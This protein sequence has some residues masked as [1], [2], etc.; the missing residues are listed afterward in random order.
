MLKP[1]NLPELS[2]AENLAGMMIDYTRDMNVYELTIDELTDAPSDWNFFRPLAEGKFFEL[3]QSIEENGLLVPLIVWERPDGG[4]MILSGHNRKRALDHLRR[5][6]GDDTYGRASCVVYRADS[7]DEGQA[8]GILVDCNWVQRVLSPSEKAR[9]IYTKYVE[10]GRRARGDGRR[11]YEDVAQHFGLKATQIYK[12]YRIAQLE[13]EWLKKMDDEELTIRA[14]AH[15]SGLSKRQRDVIFSCAQWTSAKI[16]K[17]QRDA[18]DDTI[19]TMM[20]NEKQDNSDSQMVEIRAR[21]PEDLAE[22]VEQLIS[23]FVKE[24]KVNDKKKRKNSG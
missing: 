14:A 11:R 6:S 13:D 12:Y 17:V 3:V 7:L 18:E 9:A 10:L 4:Y 23:E 1:K 16:L 5:R 2:G 21:V 24:K 20:G 15:L 22:E 8:R 19:L